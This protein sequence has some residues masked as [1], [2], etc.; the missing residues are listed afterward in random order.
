[1]P[2]LTAHHVGVTVSDLETCLAFYRDDLGLPVLEEFSLAGEAFE[3]AVGV[4][5]ATAEFAHLD[6]GGAIL[7]LVSYEPEEAACAA[8]TV[9]QRGAKHVGFTTPDLESFL[10]DLPD[11]VETLSAPQTTAT[12]S[13]IVFLRDPEGNLLEV[14]ER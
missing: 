2:E 14:L 4:P 9:A 10:A 6:A 8:E 12:G 13:T 11:A 1:M 5:G 3:A 7:E